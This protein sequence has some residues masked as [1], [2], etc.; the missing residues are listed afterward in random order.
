MVEPAAPGRI[1]QYECAST[2][3][4]AVDDRGVIVVDNSNGAIHRIHHPEAAVWTLI[5]RPYAWGRVMS[6]L[7]AATGLDGA[8][9]TS[10]LQRCL[11]EWT[12]AGLIRKTS[13]N[14]VESIAHG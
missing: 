7:S 8:A 11:A 2:T 3:T 13:K 1:I 12:A 10:L 4:W 9:A 5:Q 14:A 6:I